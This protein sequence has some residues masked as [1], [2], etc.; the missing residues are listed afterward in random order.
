MGTTP[1]AGHRRRL[2]RGKRPFRCIPCRLL[3][4]SWRSSARAW[5]TAA[6]VTLHACGRSEHERQFRSH[7]PGRRRGASLAVNLELITIDLM[8][9]VRTWWPLVLILIG[10]ALYFTPGTG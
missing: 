5:H 10:V 2:D 9:I 1:A 3:H 8:Q 4:R 7:R 6:I